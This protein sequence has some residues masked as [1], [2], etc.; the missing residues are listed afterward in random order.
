VIDTSRALARAV[1][2]EFVAKKPAADGYTLLIASP[3]SIR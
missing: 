2:A 3:S 1:A